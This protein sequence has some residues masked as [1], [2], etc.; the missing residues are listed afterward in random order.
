MKN[1]LL[2]ISLAFSI[3]VGFSTLAVAQDPVSPSVTVVDEY[4]IKGKKDFYKDYTAGDADGNVHAVIEIPKGTTGKWEVNT[5]DTTYIIWELK[6]GKPRE[7][8]YKGGYSANYGSIPQ[9]AMPKEFGGDGTAVDIVVLGAPIPR[10]EVVKVKVIGLLNITEPGGYD[11]KILAV[12]VGSPE[13]AEPSLDALN[14]KYNN[15]VAE[16]A[17]WFENYKGPDSG[18]KVKSV[19]GVDEAMTLLLAAMEAY[20]TGTN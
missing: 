2:M 20:K 7:V 3:L 5:E 8:K 17:S 19:G 10:G 18:I 13:A 15:V 4:T 14:A 11:G 9:T 6:K 16:T 1:K 12:Q